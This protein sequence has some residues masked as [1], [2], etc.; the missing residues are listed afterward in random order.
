M[1]TVF[2]NLVENRFMPKYSDYELSFKTVFRMSEYSYR[3]CRCEYEHEYIQY[4]GENDKIDRE[5]FEK[6]S[7]C[8]ING[9]CD[10]VDNVPE[11]DTQLSGINAIYIAFAIG[12]KKISQMNLKK[13]LS[14]FRYR[15][16]LDKQSMSWHF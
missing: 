8:I 12:I 3:C 9:K 11:T 6:I 13:Q 14:S 7:R 5:M 4:I 16:Y 15:K 2:E 10:H 1:A